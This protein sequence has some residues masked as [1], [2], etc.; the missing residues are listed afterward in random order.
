MAARRPASLVTVSRA[1]LT[2][3][4]GFGLERVFAGGSW[5]FAVAAAALLPPA[6][7]ALSE[8]RRWHPLV[9]PVVIVAVGF[10][11]AIFV[12]DPSETILGVPTSAAFGQFGR[13][14]G[15]AAH[16]LRSAKVPVAPNGAALVLAVVATFVTAIITE[17]VARQLEAPV[18]AI[19]PS[20]ALLVVVNALGSGAWAAATAVYALVVIAYLA[21][22]QYSELTARRTWF[23][24]ERS[25]S[26]Q[27]VTGG[28]LAGAIVVA[29]ATIVGP[30]FPGARASAWINYRSL[31][32]GKGDSVLHAPDLLVSIAA[33]LNPKNPNREDF[34]VQTAAPYYWRVQALDKFQNGD[35]SAGTNS[36]PGLAGPTHGPGAVPVSQTIHLETNAN[37]IP[38]AYR[39]TKVNGLKNATYLR[40]TSAVYVDKSGAPSGLTYTVDSEVVVPTTPELEAVTKAE[41]QDQRADT[42]LPPGFPQDVADLA[43]SV[44]SKAKAKTPY[45]MGVALQSYFQDRHNF[46]YVLDPNLGSDTHALENF[47]FHVHEGFCQQ[48][49]AAFAEMARSLGLPARVAVGFQPDGYA[50]GVYHET[51]RDAHAWPEVWMGKTIGWYAFEPTPTHFNPADGQGDKSGSKSPTGPAKTTTTTTLPGT[52]APHTTTPVTQPNSLTKPNRETSHPTKHTSSAHRAFNI[53]LISLGSLI[54]LLLAFAFWLFGRARRRTKRLRGQPDPRR[55]VFGAWNEALERLAIAGV[56]PRPSATAV[57]FALRQAPAQGAGAAGPALMDL[58]RLQTA[59]MYAREEP[60]TEEADIAWQRYDAIDTALRTSVRRSDR[61]FARLKLRRQAH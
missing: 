32:N 61:F 8:R 50:N 14:I 47:L 55:R 22:L 21:A 43:K 35:W 24:T 7:F 12:D 6:L 37:W 2:L 23:H 5:F 18:G 59:A 28:L 42:V 49:A 38:A 26:S 1:G 48:F 60:S 44:V 10:L 33:Q 45:D 56:H 16:V 27:A 36:A 20:I 34:T 29:L 52:T 39:A 53:A 57:E 54:V 51:E 30:M 3:A 19:G 9:L 58:A 40:D 46:Q 11:L 41:L 25:R 13:D 4:A 17:L 15:R 31:G